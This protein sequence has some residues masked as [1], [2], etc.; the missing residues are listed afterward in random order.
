MLLAVHVPSAG[1]RSLIMR[2]INRCARSKNQLRD[3]KPMRHSRFRKLLELAVGERKIRRAAAW[4]LRSAPQDMDRK[5]S[6][7]SMER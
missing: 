6:I 5:V 3:T 7:A 4:A 2:R 1:C